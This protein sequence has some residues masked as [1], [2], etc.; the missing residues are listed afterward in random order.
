MKINELGID[1]CPF[2][3][4]LSSVARDTV[5]WYICYECG[6]WYQHKK[7]KK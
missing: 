5:N 6:N 4:K 1:F 7:V 3:N 2:C